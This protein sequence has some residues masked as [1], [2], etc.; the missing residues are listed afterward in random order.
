M[1]SAFNLSFPAID[2]LTAELVKLGK[3]AHI[4]KIDVSREFRH[5]KKDPID[6]DLLGLNWQG[7]YI[8]TCLSFGCRHGSQFCQRRSDAIIIQD[9]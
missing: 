9:E 8:D 3:G 6:Y 2:D 7:I 5:L 4:F 1:G